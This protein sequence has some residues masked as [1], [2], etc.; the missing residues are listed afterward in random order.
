MP[1]PTRLLRRDPGGVAEYAFRLY[2]RSNPAELRD[3]PHFAFFDSSTGQLGYARRV[4]DRFALLTAAAA[5]G[6]TSTTGLF[7]SIAF[8]D[9]S[10]SFLIAYTEIFGRREDS[11]GPPPLTKVWLK[12]ILDPLGDT[13]SEPTLLEQGRFDLVTPTSVT[14]NGRFCMACANATTRALNAWVRE[15]GILTPVKHEVATTAAAVVP[16]VAHTVSGAFRIA[17]ADGDTIK[18]AAQDKFGRWNVEV[19]DEQGG[20]TPSLAYD[21]SSAKGHLAY[22]ANRTLNYAAW[23]EQ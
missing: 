19:V 5:D 1:V 20:S 2:G 3:T 12:V 6:V 17:Y 8:D 10:A 11:E 21:R 13:F 4:A 15:E 7:P 23:T 18:L 9:S 22:S 16:S 14:V